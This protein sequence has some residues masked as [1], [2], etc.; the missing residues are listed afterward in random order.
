MNVLIIEDEPLAAENM[1]RLLEESGFNIHVM[2]V[3][4]SVA[5]SV[6]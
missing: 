6:E 4:D 2:E 1:E 3:L 5:D